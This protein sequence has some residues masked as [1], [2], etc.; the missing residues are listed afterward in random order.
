M[1]AALPLCG[2]KLAKNGPDHFA[3]D[4]GQAF[5]AALMEV[6]Q[7]L[8]VEPEPVLPVEEVDDSLPRIDADPVA[9]ERAEE[10]PAARVWPANP[11][12]LAGSPDLAALT[13]LN[14]PSVL[15]NLRERYVGGKSIYTAAGPVL[16][17]V[18]P[19]QRLPELYDHNAMAAFAEGRV[20]QNEP[21]IFATAH[22]AFM[23]MAGEGAAQ[24]LVISGE[25]GA[26][27]TEST[28][29]AM[30]YLA[31]LAGSGV[32]G[33]GMEVDDVEAQVLEPRPIPRELGEDLSLPRLHHQVDVRVPVHIGGGDPHGGPT[34]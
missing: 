17:A 9:R 21:H 33:A 28:K 31:M 10:V 26:G 13:Y 25:S 14:E 29:H 34:R 12:V 24:S 20:P 15:A 19:F 22:R 7:P 32:G 3:G 1:V 30:Q 4:I 11:D 16:V 8:V 5:F 6:R 27:K 2:D 18:N 23:A